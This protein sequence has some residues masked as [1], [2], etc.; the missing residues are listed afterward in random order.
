MSRK[1]NLSNQKITALYCRISLDDGSQNESM[2]ISNQK[3]L[4]KD[5]AEKNGM[6]RYEYYV[7]D[8]YTGRNF[9]RPS[10]KRLIADIEAGKVGCVI[11]KDLSR[12]G[13]NYIEA[14][15]YIEIFFPKHNVRYIAVTDGVDS[16]TRQE[17]DI[18]PFKNIL[19]DMY[20]RDIS[21]KVLAGRMTRSRQ[22]KFCGGQPPL[23][24]MRDPEEKGHLILD[25]DTAPTI[26]KIYDLALNGWGCMRIAKQ[27]MEDKIPITRVK[28][29]TECDVNY[30][31]WGSARISHILRNPFYKGAHLVCRTHQKGIRSN[32]YDIIPREEWEVL[33]GCH[34]AIVSPE[35]WEKVQELIDRR[36]PIMEGN[37]CPFYNLFHGIIYCATCGKSMQVRYE[38]VGR[39]GKNR[40]TG[41]EREPIDKA[42]YI[43]QTYNRLGKNSCTS[44]KVEAR[45]L[46]N[47]VLKDIQELAAMA[48]KDVESFYQ[49]ISSRMERRYLA[50]ASEMEKERERLEARNREI[51]DMFLNLY[52]DKAKGILSEQR[53]VKLTAAMEREQEENQKQL[54]ELALSLRRSNEQESDVRTFIREIRQYAAVRELDEGILNRLISRILVG[55]VK[56]V[57]GE[58]F[59]EIK[60]IYNFVGEIPAV[61]E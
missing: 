51:D 50:D 36:P 32:T 35:D 33:E 46:Y 61:T 14:G 56:K 49:R 37:A 44:H 40:F 21:K 45:D 30:Y 23:G 13:R 10:F 52:T 58:K 16:L 11:T 7:D 3:L 26:R 2:S 22:G 60:I 6:P 29:N 55:E 59:Q 54:K 8:G 9:N 53:F 48:L 42:Y 12:L 41:E 5:Y 38:K 24:L 18:T 57:D 34:E 1:N 27:L 47:L 28:G 25:P 39:T 4:L 20:S 19:N 43:C 17:M 15:S 31:S